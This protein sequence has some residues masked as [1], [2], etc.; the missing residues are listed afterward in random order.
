MPTTKIFDEGK[1]PRTVVSRAKT[2]WELYRNLRARGCVIT[3]QATA[4]MDTRVFDPSSPVGRIEG[5]P[6]R[7]FKQD[8][9]DTMSD[10]VKCAL[11][12]MRLYPHF[13][14]MPFLLAAHYLIEEQEKSRPVDEIWVGVVMNE[15]FAD[16]FA[17]VQ[18]IWPTKPSDAPCTISTLTVDVGIMRPSK[19]G[20][21]TYVFGGKA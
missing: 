8:C 18:L 21:A 20:N 6:S 13:V 14:E 16:G 5:V 7:E 10:V 12:G 19:F 3:D 2:G 9:I 4:L 11:H 17:V 1:F 15:S